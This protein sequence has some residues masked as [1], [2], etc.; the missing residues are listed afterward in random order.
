MNCRVC[1]HD[2]ITV[3]D[4]YNEMIHKYLPASTDVNI[5]ILDAR[6]IGSESCK[7]DVTKGTIL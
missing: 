4:V 7:S 5:D 1:M 3:Y 2:K 6:T